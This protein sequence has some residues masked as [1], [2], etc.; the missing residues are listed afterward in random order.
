MLM[1]LNNKHKT[2]LFLTTVVAGFCLV[3]GETISET[4][5]AVI[6]GLALTWAFGSANRALRYCIGVL[7]VLLFFSP[8][9]AALIDRHSEIKN[10]ETSVKT[11]KEELPQFA[12]EHPDL[13]AG[14]VNSP[15]SGLPPGAVVVPLPRTLTIP[16]LGKVDFPANMSS[17]DIANALRRDKDHVQPP[18]WYYQALDAGVDPVETDSLLAPSDPPKPIDIWHIISDGML[19]EIPSALLAILF[20]GS[21]F[22]ER[23]PLAT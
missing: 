6:I 20:L 11:F 22:V 9:I 23:K 16:N 12:K 7:G 1:S 19:V 13:S 10:Y 2:G 15:V 8:I 17:R 4:F 14:I 3:L 21:I 5:G 18:E